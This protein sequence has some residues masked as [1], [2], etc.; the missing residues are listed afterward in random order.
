MLLNKHG[1]FYIRNGWPTKIIN[2]ITTDR[3]IFSPNNELEAVDTIGVGRVMVKAMRYW[4]V[5]M[6]LAT[7]EKTQQ[8]V[9]CNL[10]DLGNIISAYDPSHSSEAKK[11]LPNVTWADD[12]YTLCKSADAIV[13]LTDWSEF[14]ALEISRIKE[15]MSGNIV[16]DLRNIFDPIEVEAAGLKYCGIGRNR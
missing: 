14:K 15:L 9:A 10:T 13:V 4:A 5:A 1:S 7:E 6:G 8:G 2:A 11:V 3:F 16:V 12:A